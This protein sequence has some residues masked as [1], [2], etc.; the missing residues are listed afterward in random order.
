MTDFASLSPMLQSSI[1][2]FA[3]LFSSP[4]TATLALL[5]DLVAFSFIAGTAT[6]WW[7]WV[8]RIWSLS[9]AV[10]T[11]IYASFNLDK[12]RLL[13][14]AALASLWAARLTFNFWRKGGFGEVAPKEEDYRWAHV[15]SWM[16]DNIPAHLEPLARH[17][18]HALFV[19]LYQNVLLWLQVVPACIVVA[20]ASLPG[21]LTPWDY[22]AALAF[23]GL[24]ALEWLTDETQWAFQSAKHAMTPA[25]RRAAGGDFARGFCTSGVFA[26]SRHANFFAEQSMWWVFFGFSVV[27]RGPGSLQEAL[28]HYS[29][30]GPLLLTLLFQGSTMLTEAITAAK[31]PAYQDYQGH[32]SRL[33]PWLPSTSYPAAAAK[34]PSGSPK[35]S[36]PAPAQAKP[37]SASAKRR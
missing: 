29:V 26:Y 5:V 6:G 21:D 37:R 32:V 15:R 11:L 3:H 16:R 20:A 12:P 27:A 19:C 2:D 25:Q 4:F 9:P 35:P 28:L 31:Y 23:L 1:Q 30:A 10:F 14:M 24:L 18:F 13:V 17:A 22:A 8:D 33:V 36:S 7:S 34:A